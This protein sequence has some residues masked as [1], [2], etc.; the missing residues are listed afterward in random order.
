MNTNARI[1]IP[2]L[3]LALITH[4]SFTPQRIRSLRRLA[5]GGTVISPETLEAATDPKRFHVNE[6]GAGFGMSEVLPVFAT[7]PNK[8]VKGHS[9]IIGFNK[10]L[11]G[12]RVKVCEPE[13]RKLLRRR[14]IGELHLGGNG[15]ID[16]YMYGDNETFYDEDNVHWISTGDRAMMG[17][18][19]TV[20]IMGRYKDIIIRGGENLS[21]ALIENCLE[22]TGVRVGMNSLS[23]GTTRVTDVQQAQVIGI[24]DDMAG[25]IP[26][27]IIQ[28]LRPGGPPLDE[29]Q[30]LVQATLGPQSAPVAYLSLQ[31]LGLPAFPTTTSGKV[32]KDQLKT[33]VMKHLS[34]QASERIE[35]TCIA[36][37][38]MNSNERLLVEAFAEVTG[39]LAENVSLDHPVANLTDSINILRLHLQIRKR[40]NKDITIEDVLRASSIRVLAQHLERLP[41]S[42]QGEQFVPSSKGPSPPTTTEM[43]HTQGEDSQALRTRLVTVPLLDRLGMS[44]S[45]V[46]EVFP[47]PDVSA[48][49]F[50]DTRPKAYSLRMSFVAQSASK[51]TLRAALEATLQKWPISRSIAVRLDQQA[52]FVIMRAGSRWSEAAITEAADVEHPQDLVSLTLPDPERNSVHPRSGGPLTRFVIA[53][54]KSEGRAGLMILSHHSPF[55]AI[56]LQAFS[57]DLQNNMAGRP[58]E[59]LRASY[60]MF[61]DMYYL[62][63]KSLPSQIAVSFHVNR[64]RGISSLRESCWPRQRCV[65]WHIGDDE[66]Y[67]VPT[68]ANPTLLPK[69]TQIDSDRGDAGLV[70]LKGSVRL[71]GLGELR[72]RYNVS[73]PVLFKAACAILNSHLTLSPEVL[74]MNSQAGR[75]WPFLDPSIAKHL[76]NPV[77]IAGS[78]LASV[79]NRIQVQSQEALG[80]F[81]T[82]LEAEQ[83]LLT[84]YAHAPTASITSQ[85]NPGDVSAFMAGMRQLLN[86]NPVLA[87]TVTKRSGDQIGGVRVLGYTEVMLEWHCG[88]FETDVAG[89][90]VQWDGCQTGKIEVQGWLDKFMTALEWVANGEHWESKLEELVL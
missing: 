79:L 21:P 72:S 18:D 26:V 73:A 63:A 45:E 22:K 14:E 64:L 76:P 51:S 54:I 1:A 62:Y 3:F 43:V 32:R 15:V 12:A 69:R 82:R 88:M 80:S 29:M 81:L 35:D 65:G 59:E 71:T 50:E 42:N 23:L 66:G 24:P 36:V 49:C 30:T 46:E 27:A 38:K 16:R 74:F 9:G 86:W 2:G 77:T 10:I 31:E 78:T 55:D 56:S 7:D 8:P 28:Y 52:L 89:V 53:D 37:S 17:E 4:P 60:K 68:F 33:T 41:C 83:Q 13:S 70:G 90:V 6:V 19:G 48:R 34:V 61:A 11:T 25:E 40:T 20:Y 47:V 67:T 58:T 5:F 87:E 57:E 85:L 75:Q 39:Q 44:W 84:A